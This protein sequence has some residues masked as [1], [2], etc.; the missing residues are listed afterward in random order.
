MNHFFGFTVPNKRQP[1]EKKLY[2]HFTIIIVNAD[3][4]FRTER[5]KSGATN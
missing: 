4:P 3:G 2:H 5:L 1:E